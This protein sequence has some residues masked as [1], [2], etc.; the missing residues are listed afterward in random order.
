[1]YDQSMSKT[2]EVVRPNTKS[3]LLQFP[4]SL[5]SACVVPWGENTIFIIGGWPIPFGTYFFNIETSELRRGP[6]LKTGRWL[7]GCAEVRIGD[8]PSIIVAGG[9]TFGVHDTEI[10]DKS[11]WTQGTQGWTIG[12]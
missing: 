3:D 6:H 12:E 9:N 4:L 7:H 8:R 1:M 2:I 5:Q 11:K 10:L